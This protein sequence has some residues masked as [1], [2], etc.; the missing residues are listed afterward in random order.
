DQLKVLAGFV[1][2]LDLANR[3]YRPLEAAANG[4]DLYVM[5]TATDAFGW[6]RVCGK[7][8]I[9][10][11]EFRIR[12]LDDRPYTV[13]WV[14]PWSGKTLESTRVPSRN[15]ELA[16]TVPRINDAHPDVAFRIAE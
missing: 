14:D 5:G 10:G 16:I 8:E 13:S 12:G 4:T 9:G 2:A 7:E 11:K 1:S 3:P 6:G 15:G